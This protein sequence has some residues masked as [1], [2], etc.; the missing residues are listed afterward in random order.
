MIRDYGGQDF[1]V[2][3]KVSGIM[4]WECAC[5]MS[6]GRPILRTT[7]NAARGLCRFSIHHQELFFLKDRPP[8]REMTPPSKPH[9]TKTVGNS[10][11][12]FA[13]YIVIKSENKDTNWHL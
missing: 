5:C 10:A 6:V 4:S 8:T 12:V 3:G 9:L 2:Y 7:I 11:F 13:I 1:T